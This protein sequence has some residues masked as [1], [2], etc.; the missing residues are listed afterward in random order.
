LL[1]TPVAAELPV[2]DIRCSEALGPAAAY[3][4]L[5]QPASSNNPAQQLLRLLVWQQSYAVQESMHAVDSAIAIHHHLL[6]LPL[7]CHWGT[8]AALALGLTIGCCPTTNFAW[9]ASS[10]S[11]SADNQQQKTAGQSS[12]C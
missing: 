8:P 11:C 3:K 6:L 2:V 4:T 10:L 1:C 9:Q 5:T 7:G 12:Q